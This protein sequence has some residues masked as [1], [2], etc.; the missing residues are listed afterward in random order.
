MAIFP[1]LTL[2]LLF[3]STTLQTNAFELTALLTEPLKLLLQHAWND[4]NPHS[5]N[6][7]INAAFKGIQEIK[8]GLELM[9]IEILYGDSVKR[10][11]FFID[12]YNEKQG[13]V[14]QNMA[15]HMVNDASDNG[16]NY[17][18]RDLNSMMVGKDTLFTDE[19]IFEAVAVTAKDTYSACIEIQGAWNYLSGLWISGH[20][21][22]SQAYRTLNRNFEEKV[23]EKKNETN[24][25]LDIQLPFRNKAFN[26]RCT[27]DHCYEYGKIY[28]FSTV[29]KTKG[30][31]STEGCNNLCMVETNCNLWTFNGPKNEC[32]MY[33][34]D[35]GSNEVTNMDV[36]SGPKVCVKGEE[37]LSIFG[38]AFHWSI[39][40]VVFF[41][42]LGLAVLC[43]FCF[44]CC[45]LFS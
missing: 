36:V 44:C 40:L 45:A 29:T 27:Y 11:E 7:K 6:N 35:N 5:L 17:I 32:Y 19:S 28:T 16:F 13:N 18:L 22:W 31:E 41:S 1:F 30:V 2:L 38:L 20:S 3:N 24:D 8:N 26:S 14:N 25:G 21:V 43:C 4:I 39:C 15:E 23:I 9:K 42:I 10:I 34:E 33:E 12:E 37:S